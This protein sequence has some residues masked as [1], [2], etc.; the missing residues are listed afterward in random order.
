MKPVAA[1]Y[2]FAR[3]AH[4]EKVRR[5]CSRGFTLIELL[6]TLTVLAIVLA[7]AVPSFSDLMTSNRI[8]TQT[9][10]FIGALNLARS[11]AVR[12]SQPVTLLADNDDNYSLGWKVFP[13]ANADGAAA[14]ATNATD[15]QPI[16]ENGVFSGTI[17]ITRVTRSAPPAPFTYTTS[18]DAAR[19]HLVFTARGAI[20]PV[21]P[22][23]FK[24]CDPSRTAIK[25]RIVQV[26]VVGK[27]SLDSVNESCT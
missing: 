17:T 12:R 24:V 13:D 19:M 15:G 7:L 4:L 10:E 11:E 1:E 22:A 23:F 20:A 6:V 16:R 26:N 2:E 8:S 5:Q 9:N 25:G 18:T 14:G 3:S 27:I 21:L